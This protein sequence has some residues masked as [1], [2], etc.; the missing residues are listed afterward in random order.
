MKN[1][2]SV[3]ILPTPAQGRCALNSLHHLPPRERPLARSLDPE[4]RRLQSQS[5]GPCVFVQIIF[6]K[7]PPDLL[8]KLV[9]VQ[10]RNSKVWWVDLGEKLAEID[11]W[12]KIWT[13]FA[14]YSKSCLLSVCWEYC[15]YFQFAKISYLLTDLIRNRCF[16]KMS[17]LY[18]TLFMYSLFMFSTDE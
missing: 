9:P 12:N 18:S 5:E 15:Q 6:E 4:I 14:K 1:D 8:V 13:L 17:N 3:I 7:H 16:V 11:S 10:R 2:Y